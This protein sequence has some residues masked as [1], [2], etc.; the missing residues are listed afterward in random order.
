MTEDKDFDTA[1]YFCAGICLRQN[2]VTGADEVLVIEYIKGEQKP[3]IKLPGG[4]SLPGED[5]RDT[6]FR[7]FEKETS[8]RIK[9]ATE[10]HCH[11]LRKPGRPPHDQVFYLVQC[12][13]LAELRQVW[14]QDGP[15][16]QLSPPYW[17]GIGDAL[18]EQGGLFPSHRQAFEAAIKHLTHWIDNKGQMTVR[19]KPF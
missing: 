3:Q 12:V 8:C 18:R 17:M 11:E 16:E 13:D 15:D 7:E 14:Q 1:R 10:I 9:S 5:K 2:P 6:F 4:N 19:T